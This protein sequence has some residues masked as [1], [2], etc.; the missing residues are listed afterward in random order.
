MEKKIAPKTLSGHQVAVMI[1]SSNKRCD[2]FAGD[3]KGDLKYHCSCY[4]IYISLTKIEQYIMTKRKSE[5]RQSILIT[6][7]STRRLRSR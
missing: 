3:M 4:S 6:S 5:D 7:P 2:E 1:E